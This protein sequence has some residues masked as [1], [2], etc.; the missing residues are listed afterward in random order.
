M[1]AKRKRVGLVFGIDQRWIAGSYYIMNVVR[2]LNTLPD[3]E[4]PHI[5]F[6]SDDNS[7]ISRLNFPYYSYI[8]P[9]RC[10]RNYFEAA[11]NKIIKLFIQED[12]ID[13]RLSD[14]HI[15]ILFP[16]SSEPVF[17][18]V[19]NKIY[20]I[21]DFQHH[22]YPNFFEQEEIALR[23][24]EFQK[25][26]NSHH[27]LVL[28]SQAAFTDF[29]KFYPD[30]TV[31]TKV[32]PFAVTHPDFSN[33]NI[34]DL[35]QKYKISNNYYI[36]S[37]QFWQHKN[38]KVVLEALNFLILKGKTIDFQV[39]FTGKP[40]DYR[41]PGFY[42]ELMSF[43]KEK[44]IESYLRFIGFIPRTEQLRLMQSSIAI[45][46]PS[47]FEGWSTVVEDAKALNK[48]I[49]LSNISVHQEQAPINGKYFDPHQPEQLANL[50]DTF[51]EGIS[52]SK[53]GYDYQ[54]DIKQFGE[55]LFHLFALD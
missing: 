17:D 24:E 42:Q 40:D 52:T 9:Y 44:K 4:K 48:T 20:W 23:N 3:N 13:K 43:V 35:K 21:P 8:N 53:K 36:V 51:K 2:A 22:F 1:A 27:T 30:A 31:K 15:S 41:A 12:S 14:K 39:V 29:E 10:R 50:L 34:T 6:L 18:K 46:Q 25:I 16:A 32:I 28:S 33:E 7:A 11:L 47:L 49:F 38:H 45:V 37:N 19:S 55:K 5:V 26:A 54:N